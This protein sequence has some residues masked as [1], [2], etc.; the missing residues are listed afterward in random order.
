MSSMSHPSS[1][2]PEMHPNVVRT[3]KM[4]EI[5][6]EREL[7]NI[8]IYNTLNRNRT[9]Q[10]LV[11]F[12][13]VHGPRRMHHQ[14]IIVDA[15]CSIRRRMYQK[16]TNQCVAIGLFGGCSSSDWE[17]DEEGYPS[18]VD[19]GYFDGTPAGLMIWEGN[20]LCMTSKHTLWRRPTAEELVLISEGRSLFPIDPTCCG[21]CEAFSSFGWGT[22]VDYSRHTSRD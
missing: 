22:I 11:A 15:T 1:S 8:G 20:S 13:P 14:A 12:P 2:L 3:M 9:A 21:T 17:G 19:G 7:A 5:A 16:N 6:F 4:T 10:A 18:W